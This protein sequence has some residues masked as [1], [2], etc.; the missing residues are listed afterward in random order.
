V[1]CSLFRSLQD[2]TKP[3]LLHKVQAAICKNINLYIE[4]YE[5]EFAPYLQ[6]F[7]KDIWDL[8]LKL[9]NDAKYDVV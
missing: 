4:K 9:G 3:G 6:T 5:E 2:D 8:T 7:V 1:W